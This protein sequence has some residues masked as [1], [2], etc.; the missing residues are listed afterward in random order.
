MCYANEN[1]MKEK[2]KYL[3]NSADIKAIEHIA[4]FYTIAGVTTNPSLVA[5]EK[6]EFLPLI[7]P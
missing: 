1:K 2:K 5:K 4:E 7:T 3:I 6:T